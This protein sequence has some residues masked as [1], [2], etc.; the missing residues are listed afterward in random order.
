M[1][2]DSRPEQRREVPEHDGHEFSNEP[3][4]LG[5]CHVIRVLLSSFLKLGQGL[6]RTRDHGIGLRYQSF[7]QCW[8][9]DP[10]GHLGYQF[11]VGILG[12]LEAL[13]QL[14][15]KLYHMTIS[16]RRTL[17][18]EH[19]F[20][21]GSQEL[22][23]QSAHPVV[24]GLLENLIHQLDNDGI[25]TLA[26]IVHDPCDACLVVIVLLHSDP[27]EN[28]SG[29]FEYLLFRLSRVRLG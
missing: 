27:R 16:C 7:Y 10:L 1:I 13:E 3:P 12:D 15:D 6:E 24:S 28:L 29:L 5:K 19:I 9:V 23:D 18:V 11:G 14:N 20:L 25:V 17:R 22:V 26:E 21:G 2:R 8:N 4:L